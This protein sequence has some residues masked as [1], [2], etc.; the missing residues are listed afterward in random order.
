MQ[1]FH[2]RLRPALRQRSLYLVHRCFSQ[3]HLRRC[4]P[5]SRPCR[6]CHHRRL[7]TP[8][9]PCSLPPPLLPLQSTPG[10]SGRANSHINAG[11]ESVP[12]LPS[13][14]LPT[15]RKLPVGKKRSMGRVVMSVP[16]LILGDP[17]IANVFARRCK[18]FLGTMQLSH[19][20]APGPFPN[21]DASG[22]EVASSF[23]LLRKNNSRG[24]EVLP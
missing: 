10:S 5:V 17:C 22:D 3:C 23:Q 6:R 13:P 12:K 20:I 2:G 11:H 7:D 8:T 19:E 1:P 16:A 4:L 9:L 21:R 15:S 18:V 14:R 24:A